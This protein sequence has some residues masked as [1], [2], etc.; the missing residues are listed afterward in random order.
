MELFI[1]N[2]NDEFAREVLTWKYDQPYDF[3]NSE[4]TQEELKERLN[5]TYFALVNKTGDLYGFFCIGESAQVPKGIKL[6]IYEDGFVDMGL[7]MN[8]RLVG[9]GNGLEFCS[10]I[11]RYIEQKFKEKPIRLTVAKFN[12]RAIHLYKKIGFIDN[13]EFD[14]EFAEFITM[15]KTSN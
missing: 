10:F 14:T 4:F 6:N 3:Y 5:G 12:H 1:Q 9:K 15:V 2:M 11:V 8:P 13:E 7:G